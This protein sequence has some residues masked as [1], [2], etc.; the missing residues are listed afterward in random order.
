MKDDFFV[1]W[2]DK[3]PIRSKKLGFRFFMT[4]LVLVLL[5]AAIFVFSQRGFIDSYFEYGTLTEKKG[6]LVKDPVWGLQTI[7]NGQLKTIPLVGFGKFGPDETLKSIADDIGGFDGKEI[8]IRGTLF[9]Y[10]DKEW[11][12]LTE[13]FGSLVGYT[14]KA[15][16]VRSIIDKGLQTVEG[17]I[18]DPKCF[19][20][21]MNPAEK[22]VHRSCAIRCISGGIPPVMAVRENGEFVDYYFL[23]DESGNPL[24]QIILPYV[25]IPVT[26]SGVSTE[27]DDWKA[28]KV[29]SDIDAQILLS[30]ILSGISE[31][32]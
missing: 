14:E 27:Y 3:T 28:L 6:F 2:S 19:F 4:V 24:N 30:S 1:G 16:P 7:E 15:S 31:C 17:E 23:I 9:Y 20:G 12:E 26:L 11:M 21:V 22:A 25:G 32:K 5:I 29:P 8:T 18:V 13:G 10:Q